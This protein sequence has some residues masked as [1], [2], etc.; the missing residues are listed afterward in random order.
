[1]P[2]TQ[3]KHNHG[4][5]LIEVLIALLVLAI[6]LLGMASL[7]VTSMQS[8]QASAQRSAAIVLS[9]DLVERMRSNRAQAV[10]SASPFAGNPATVLDPCLVEDACEDGMTPAQQVSNDLA[11]WAITLGNAIPGAAAIIDQVGTTN[12]FCIAIFWPENQPNLVA[13]DA[14]ACGTNADNRAFTRLDV[15]L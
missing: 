1:M 15:N 12:E 6:G 14:T 2:I 13:D 3:R 9:Y 11:Q 4:F 7:M 8:N 5:T 10:L